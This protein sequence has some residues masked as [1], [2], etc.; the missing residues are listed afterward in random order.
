MLLAISKVMLLTILY[1][2]HITST[3]ML[4]HHIIY[5]GKSAHVAVISGDYILYFVFFVKIKSVTDQT[6]NNKRGFP[7]AK[8]LLQFVAV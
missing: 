8:F 6:D 1:L 2:R 7:L 3:M 4:L 5:T